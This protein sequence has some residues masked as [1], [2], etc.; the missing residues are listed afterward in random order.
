MPSLFGFQLRHKIYEGPRTLIFRGLREA[1][2]SAVVVK[3]YKVGDQHARTRLQRQYSLLKRIAADG[4]VKTQSLESGSIG[5]A[6][7]MTDSGGSSLEQLLARRK[8]GLK[9]TISIGIRIA[10][11]LGHLHEQNLIHK[12]INPAHIIWNPKD[13]ALELIG[14]SGTSELVH[15]V[16]PSPDLPTGNLNYISPEQTGRMNRGLDYR[17][18]FYSLGATLYKMATGRVLF[19]HESDSLSLAHAHLARTPTPPSRLDPDI[20]TAL[21]DVI[22]K[23]LAKTA[24]ERY[25]SVPGLIYDLK[26][27]AKFLD[28]PEKAE[29]FILGSR[30]LNMRFRISEQLFGRMKNIQQ[31]IKA[32]EET[33][34]G[35]PGVV[36]VRGPSGIGK[37]TLVH[38]IYKPVTRARGYFIAGKFNRIEAQRPYT[39]LVQAL[40]SLFRQIL[41]EPEERVMVWRERM[42]RA[43]GV[44]GAVIMDLA[45]EIVHLIGEQEP[46]PD[47]PPGETENRFHLVIRDFFEALASQDHPL[48]MFLDDVQWA[49]EETLRL[50]SILAQTS[51]LLLICSCRDEEH[52]ALTDVE[53]VL[54]S[55]GA[56]MT[57]ISPA[58]LSLDD[59]TQMIAASLEVEP[60]DVLALA[61]L[62]RLRSGGVPFHL[63]QYFG[64]LHEK[65]LIRF[66]ATRQTWSWDLEEIRAAGITEN[67]ADLMLE[68]LQKLSEDTR[69]L[70]CMGACM[71]NHFELA[72]LELLSEK[73][74]D[75]LIPLLEKAIQ[76]ELIL[77]KQDDWNLIGEENTRN[78]GFRFFHDKVHQAAYDLL[79]ETTRTKFHLELGNRLLA[80]FQANEEH[81]FR[82]VNHLNQAHSLINDLETRET[83]ARHNLEA[84]DRALDTA[85]YRQAL[86]WL[87]AGMRLLPEDTWQTHYRLTLDIYTKTARAAWLNGS[88]QTLEEVIADALAH[89]RTLQDKID[90]YEIKFRSLWA[91]NQLKEAVESGLEILEQMG[92]RFP[93]KPRPLHLRWELFKTRQ[94]MRG[95]SVS[96]LLEL[97]DVQDPMGLEQMRCLS[98]IGAATYATRPELFPLMICRIVRLS[99]KYGNCGWSAVAYTLYGS[100]LCVQKSSYDVGYRFA[101]MGR[102]LLEQLGERRLM[103]RQCYLFNVFVRHYCEPHRHA[104]PDLWQGYQNGLEIGDFESAAICLMA[105]S[106][107]VNSSLFPLPEIAEKHRYCIRRSRQLGIDNIKYHAGLLLLC[108]L[109]MMNRNPEPDDTE[110]MP[111]VISEYARMFKKTRDIWAL[112]FYLLEEVRYYYTMEAYT[113]AMTHADEAESYSRRFR[114][115]AALG[116]SHILLTFYHSLTMLALYPFVGPKKRREFMKKTRTATKSFEKLSRS[117]KDNFRHRLNLL[118]AERLRVMGKHDQAR[119][120]YDHAITDVKETG[121]IGEEAL[122]Y[123]LTARFY[124][125]QKN[126][127]IA[128]YFFQKAWFLYSQ[129]GASAK[130]A[131]LRRRHPNIF[132]AETREEHVDKTPD[133]ILDM[134]HLDLETILEASQA[135]GGE[136]VLERLLTKMM[137]IV[138]KNAGAQRGCLLLR[139]ENNW[140][141]MAEGLTAPGHPD[142]EALEIRVMQAQPI[143]GPEERRQLLPR[144]LIHYVERTREA[145]VLDN[146]AKQG[147][148]A[149]D[150]YV[151][152]YQT[153][154]ALCMPLLHQSHLTGMLYLENNLADGSFTA[155]RVELLELLSSQM[156]ISIENARFYS[157]L[158]EKVGIRTRELR[159]RNEDILRTQNQLI[160]KEKIASL[161]MLTAGIAHEIKNPLN[162]VNNFA[163]L[164]QGLIREALEEQDPKERQAILEDLSQNAAL[165][166]KN[167]DRANQIVESMMAFTR[168]GPGEWRVWEINSLV[169]RCMNLARHGN[170]KVPNHLEIKE[171]Y[172]EDVGSSRIQPRNLTRALINLFNNAFEA[173]GEKFRISGGEYRPLL[174]IT[175]QKLA[176]AIQILIYDNGPGIAEE[177]QDHVFTHFFTRKETGSGHIGLG[178]SICF[179]VVVKEHGGHIEVDS[180]P[181]SHTEMIVTLPLEPEETEDRA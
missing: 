133:Q 73:K 128:R 181:G 41:T 12:G 142:E 159:K 26:L 89:G 178:L 127:E 35:K 47:L 101:V 57:T 179:E 129:W 38:E 107:F 50:L 124:Q 109:R 8:P 167:G 150:P 75:E 79:D 143:P 87:E 59:T 83:L 152:R 131:Q 125:E 30:D 86:T 151:K 7:V 166:A 43:L 130:L 121:L 153:R 11:T 165:I 160:I 48:V 46:V 18:D 61:D 157:E 5:P 71:G 62:L 118:E 175:T 44:N 85:A 32:F 60:V 49:G 42:T 96:G 97:P 173:L 78:V 110:D 180:K 36:L 162:F 40:R 154:S 106:S 91:R 58:P 94:A 19:P 103:S 141:I 102:D 1:D 20:P 65:N 9:R 66:D 147:L 120:L 164:Q 88:W 67:I 146:A 81:L 25:Q 117:S 14:F 13:N 136:I 170:A 28:E 72:L 45:P 22:M 4:I 93:K 23:L 55:V 29:G 80:R 119:A 74:P 148:A 99:L 112:F 132:R 163:E 149:K 54:A 39:A 155:H 84:A 123:E 172:D 139:P 63:K 16:S 174:R 113:T 21:S 122:V 104:L 108:D 140:V 116:M 100:M 17:S 134:G 6:M 156:A 176:D 95:R 90:I 137:K 31:L 15:E 105:G 70:L 2:L 138:L 24:E 115:G 135:I 27:C 64:A 177:D 51:H 82:M 69:E 52:Q 33:I 126:E 3:F 34:E 37:T 56:E 114:R 161:G 92:Q 158:E 168:E 10:E 171:I 76:Q 77:P 144:A 145:V 68:R 98:I 53:S 111:M 169:N